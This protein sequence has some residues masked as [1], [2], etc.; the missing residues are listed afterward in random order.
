[1]LR[2]NLDAATTQ[3]GIRSKVLAGVGLAEVFADAALAQDMRA[4]NV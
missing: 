3:S 4:L 2:E 1:M